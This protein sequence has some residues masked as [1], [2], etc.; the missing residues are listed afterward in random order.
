MYVEAGNE[1]YDVDEI[2][3]AKPNEC[4][5]IYASEGING[6]V[7]GGEGSRYSEAAFQDCID[8]VANLCVSACGEHFEHK[9]TASDGGFSEGCNESDFESGD[10]Y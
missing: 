3:Q 1:G 8:M 6:S 7:E 2:L 5:F 10:A 4:T 9:G